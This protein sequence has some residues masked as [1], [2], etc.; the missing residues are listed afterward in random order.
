M[1]CA[2]RNRA[3]LCRLLLAVG[4]DPSLLDPAGRDALEIAREAGAAEAA[5]AIEA[6]LVPRWQPAPNEVPAIECDF[7]TA[8]SV[9]FPEPARSISELPRSDQGSLPTAERSHVFD[10]GGWE[11]EEEHSTPE[12]DPLL[13]LAASQAQSKITA[14]SPI[15]T[16]A[17]WDE[18]DAFLPDRA[19]PLSRDQDAEARARLRLALLR[20]LREG[21]IPDQILDDLSLGADGQFDARA[22]A[23]L[24]MVVNDLG[25]E[26]DERFE[27]STADESFEVFVAPEQSP[28]EE[29]LVTEAMTFLDDLAYPRN[30][31]LRIYQRELQREP[32]LTATEEVA[33]GQAMEQGIERALDALSSWPEGLDAVL[34]AAREV[35]EGRRTL[36]SVCAGSASEPTPADSETNERAIAASASEQPGIAGDLGSDEDERDSDF[37]AW[38]AGDELTEFLSRAE[39]LARSRQDGAQERS[40]RRQALSSLSLSRGFLV[41]LSGLPP[42]AAA[43]PAREFRKAIDACRGARDRM[44]AANLK[45]VHSIAKKYLFS[46]LP[47]DDLLQEGNIGLMRAVD[48]FEWRKGFRFSTYATWWIRQQVGRFV[49]DYGRTI[50]LPVHVHEK[51]QRIAQATRAFELDHGRPPSWDELAGIVD[52]PAHKVKALSRWDAEPLPL[53]EVLQVDELMDAETQE[54]FH[55]PDPRECVEQAQLRASV[56]RALSELDEKE[57]EI[58][59]KRFGIGFTD[60]MTLEEIGVEAGVTRERIRQI[61]SKAMKRLKHPTRAEPLREEVGIEP[62]PKKEPVAIFAD[63]AIYGAS[64]GESGQRVDQTWVVRAENPFDKA[65][66]EAR[67]AGI[68]TPSS[69]EDPTRAEARER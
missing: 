42:L 10:L 18:F 27:Y 41:E 35:V 33:L 3:S 17:D 58:V 65:M 28:L 15:D 47:L 40:L 20:A 16:S 26:I 13:A 67:A 63:H 22:R 56:A 60:S 62:E 34:A 24:A 2:A 52:I 6:A 45:L 43:G 30:D 11:A 66:R 36:R 32:L 37:G 48:R 29:D 59:R 55:A 23:A 4:A 1:L 54:R 68:V 64:A 21:S 53:D 51:T 69:L 50:R 57:Q 61:E 31:P 39:T 5:S 49:A 46:G 19:A 7:N 8:H 44:T 14:H 9:N 38:D 25:A 12:G